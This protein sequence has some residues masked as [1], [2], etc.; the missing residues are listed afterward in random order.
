MQ[1]WCEQKKSLAHVLGPLTRAVDEIK[2]KAF[3]KTS[4]DGRKGS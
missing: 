3:T 2:S 4:E 1:G